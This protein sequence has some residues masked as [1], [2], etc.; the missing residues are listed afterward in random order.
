VSTEEEA[1]VARLRYLLAHG[2]KEDLVAKLRDWPGA[3]C[4]E[5]LATGATCTG[6]WFG[7][8]REWLV[9]L[10]RRIARM[11]AEIE[12]EAEARHRGEGGR[13]AI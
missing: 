11:I 9:D 1:Q 8:H 7:R 5:A 2:W 12:A 6:V 3:L 4:A 13:P 10:Q